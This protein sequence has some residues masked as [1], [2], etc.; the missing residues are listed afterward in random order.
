MSL[1]DDLLT[2]QDAAAVLGVETQTLAKWRCQKSYSLR[3]IKVGGLV[4][5]RRSD[6][7]QFLSDR[8]VTN[9]PVKVRTRTRN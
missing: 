4:R 1:P 5:Y 2:P 6:L 3:Y 8:T 7:D 9:D